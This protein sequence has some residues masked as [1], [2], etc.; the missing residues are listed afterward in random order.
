MGGVNADPMRGTYVVVSGSPGSGKTTLARQL[1]TALQL[2]LIAKDTIKEALMM[3]LDVPDV[4]ASREL[5]RAAVAVLYAVA[6]DSGCGVLESPWQRSHAQGELSGL[7]GSIVE[8]FCRCDPNVAQAR[9]RVRAGTRAAGHFDGERQ[10][11]E[12][13]NDE[14]GQPVAGGWPVVAVDTDRPVDL[15]MLLEQIRASVP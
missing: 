9:Y 6:K 5:G 3:V 12:L 10:A 13:W 14:V 15:G 11:G 4:D 2:P 8:V 1:A 7:P